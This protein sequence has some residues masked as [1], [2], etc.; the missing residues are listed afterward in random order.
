MAISELPMDSVGA[1]PGAG[2][3]A[4]VPGHS[5]G[6]GAAR[7]GALLDRDWF[8]EGKH[9]VSPEAVFEALARDESEC[10]AA[11]L[12]AV[13]REAAWRETFAIAQD[14]ARIELGR[15]LDKDTPP[16][17]REFLHRW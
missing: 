3:G 7:L 4:G 13:A 6:R 17:V 2:S 11:S 5:S 16:I 14:E 15:R 10:R 9:P 1:Q 12:E 8:E